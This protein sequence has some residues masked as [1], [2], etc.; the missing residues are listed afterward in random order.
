MEVDTCISHPLPNKT[1]LKFDQD[2][3]AWPCFCQYQG[4]L[5]VWQC[6]C[7]PYEDSLFD[8]LF[9]NSHNKSIVILH[10]HGW[11]YY[12]RE[13]VKTMTIKSQSI[14]RVIN[15]LCPIPQIT[16]LYGKTLFIKWSFSNFLN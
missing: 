4:P 13:G 8:I 10:L 5:C 9:V 6:L 12:F 3:E 7:S 11:S 2:F 14:R 16:N 1:K 15:I